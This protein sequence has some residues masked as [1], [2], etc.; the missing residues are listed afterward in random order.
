MIVFHKESKVFHLYNASFSY[1]FQIMRNGQLGQLYAGARIHDR[2]DFSHLFELCGRAMSICPYE[3]ERMFSLE[4]LKQEYPGYGTGYFRQPAITVLQENGSRILELVYTGHEIFAGKPRLAGLPATYT[5]SCEEAQTLRVHLRDALTGVEV[6]LLYTIFE[7]YS[8]LARS[9]RICNQGSETVHVTRAMSLCLDLPDSDYEWLQLSGAWARERYI[10]TRK[11]EP[12]IQSIGSLRGHSSSQHNPFVVLKR[13]HA[14]ERQGEVLGF[15]FV[16]SGNFLMQ[17]ETDTHGVTRMLVGIHPETFDWKLEPGESLQ[18]PEAVMV[19]SKN[20]LNDM[21][22][23]FHKLYGRRL[24]RGYWRDR[25]RPILNNNWE[26]TYFDFTEDR[27]VEIAQKAKECGV[28]LFVLDDGWFGARTSDRAG[29]GDWVANRDRLPNGIEG[30]ADKIE[31]LGM[32]FGLWFEPEMVNKD[33]DLY[34]THPDWLLQV[35]GRRNSHGRNQYVL[36]FSRKEVVDFIHESMAKILREAKVSYIKW[37]MNRS[38]TECYSAA[39]PADRQGEVFHRYILGVYDLYERLTSEFPKVLFESCSSG[40]ARFDAGMLYYAPQAWA[41]DDSDAIE[42]LKI[43]YG[44]SLCYPISSIGSHVSV[45]PNH[46]VNRVTPLHTRANVAYFGT[47]GYELDLNKLSE[48]EIAQVK[49]QIAFMKE[50]RELLQF[51]TFYRLVSPFEDNR[52]V[53]MVVSDDQKT[54]IV[55]WYRVLNR[56]NDRFERVRLMGLN[57]DF[58]YKNELAGTWHYGDELMNV[59]LITTDASAGEMPAGAALC[60][61]FESRIYVLK[62]EEHEN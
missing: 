3:G 47:F 8:A 58:V 32:K 51:G 16:Y 54:A 37:D 27:L 24:A 50:Y 39:L 17:A 40:G 9:V 60:S 59:G 18:M 45:V 29:L 61:D 12:G 2:K 30:I 13:P 23:T 6:E 44:T 53:W 36:D 35:P 57:P 38:I 33:S 34:R 55:G 52:T 4:H 14:D 49:E 11:L 48:E 20:G 56:V 42:R 19:Y 21:S 22:Q 26:A 62:A 41:S 7:G 1:V 28:E 31:A 46:Q 5:E 25:P 10:H 15:S 43:Q